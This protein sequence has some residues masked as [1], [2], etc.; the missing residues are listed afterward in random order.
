MKIITLALLLFTAS[1]EAIE[2]WADTHLPVTNG[3]ALWLDAASEGKAPTPGLWHDG[4]GHQRHAHQAAAGA[5]PVWRLVSPVAAFAFDGQSQHFVIDTRDWSMREATVFVVARVLSNSGGYRGFLSA[6]RPGA[7]DYVTGVN[8]DLGGSSSESV[9]EMNIEGA[10]FAGEQNLL[11]DPIPFGKP[12]AADFRIGQDK[13]EA[14]LSSARPGARPRKPGGSMDAGHV[15]IGA[16]SFDNGGRSPVPHGFLHGDVFE[17]LVYDRALST[18]EIQSVRHYLSAKYAGVASLPVKHTEQSAGSVP[19]VAVKNPPLIQPLVPGFTARQLP[20]RLSNINFLRYRPDGRLFAGAYDGTIY[21]LRDTDGDGLPDKATIYYQ[22]A[23]LKAVM[24]MALTPP[25]YARGE[26]VFV[27][28]Q[29]RVILILDTDGDGVGDEVVTV[30]SGWEHA[31]VVTQGVSDALGVAVGPDGKIYFNLGTSDFTNGYL[32]DRATGKAGYRLGSERGTIQ[33]VSAD[34]QHRATVS[35]GLRYNVGL[36][37][38]RDGDL[39]AT[40][41]EGATW[42]ANGNPLDELLHIQ[43]GRHYG[44]P[45]HHPRHLPEVVDEP[46]TFDYAPQHQSTVGLCFNEPLR[47]GAPIFGPGWWRGDALIAAMSRGKIYRTTLVKT[48]AGYVARN[49][50]FAQLQRIIIDQAVS[51]AGALTVTLHSGAPDWGSGPKGLGELWQIEPMKM[52][53][54]QPAAAWSA[55]PTELRV[56]FDAPLSSQALAAMQ[57][58]VRV[59]QGRYVQA[60]DR[61]ETMRPGYQVVKNQLA[62]PRFPIQVRKV[63]LAE[64]GRTLVITTPARTAAVNYGIT[65]EADV[66]QVGSNQPFAGQIDLMADLTGLAAV[67]KA[68]DG[69]DAVEAWL[70]HLDF[71]VARSLTATG[72]ASDSFF[73]VLS[74]PG[75]ITLAGQLDLGLMLFPAVQPGSKLDWEY[76]A[77]KVTVQLSAAR[78]FRFTLGSNITRSQARDGRHEASCTVEASEGSWFGLTVAFAP[79]S[80]NPELTG[81]WFTDRS[82]IPRP[83]PLRRILLPYARPQELAPAVQ[84]EELPQL[85]GAN[86]LRGQA[87]FQT[88]CVVCH[89]M[90]GAGGRVGPD[91]S[92]L[93]YRDYDSVLRDIREPSAAINPEHV[94][95]T[96]TKKNGEELT[97]VLLSD[98]PD[99]VTLALASG[100]SV[101]IPRGDIASMKQL[102]Q[103]LMPEG[104]DK[105]FTPTQL[106]DLMSYLLIPPM[107]PAPLVGEEAPAPRKSMEVEKILGG[108][109]TVGPDPKAKPLRIVLCAS[110]KDKGHN[111]PGLHDYP[112]WRQ[113]WSRLLAMAEGMSV[114]TSNNWPSAEQWSTADVIAINSYNPA[115]ADEK[116]PAAIDRR[117]RDI[118][119]FLARG[120]GLVV[121]HY[122]LNSGGH[123]AEFASRVGLAW[124]AGSRFR[125]GAS[126]WV[127]DHAHPLA[128]GFD[129]FQIPD[130]SY[131][132]LT[133]N[134]AAAG[135]RVLATSL[136]DNAPRPQMWTREVGPGRVFVSIPGHFTWTYD[137]PLYR[138]LIFR[139]LM[140][141]AH[142]PLD[143]L[144]PL[145]TI[146]ARIEP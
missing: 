10:G 143:R 74:R 119:A 130:E 46:S 7:N 66:F 68:T 123:A 53:P 60:G 81:S 70:P 32:V 82:S 16:R 54:P 72:A 109:L 139:G 59:T 120:G 27:A 43:R 52:L 108:A 49:Q 90:R 3:L 126:D 93:I 86:W 34:F 47:E 136:E 48:A 58:R 8:I 79:G 9:S 37:F 22:S 112:I 2:P 64:A 67:W 127:L 135:A 101:E 29:G 106:R 15:L 39:F 140:W 102:A 71:A 141:S 99:S 128:A 92:N 133:G 18:A 145:V 144:A 83:F 107:E 41:Q 21:L 63:A 142:Q 104:M 11:P 131:W 44:F 96:M 134:L 89:P 24:G 65:I 76:P 19:L 115:W 35:T 51:P 12:F 69:P 117:G 122:A 6:S 14:L 105:I 28:S 121:L 55:S 31:V 129:G 33:E 88:A 25:G 30:A 80:G 23:D 103:S 1:V 132:N 111:V 98:T 95:Y 84:Q 114:E 113:R 118:D 4:S 5:Q 20:V 137:D 62:T 100:Q 57:G 50:I 125:H 138:I 42:L 75:T 87:H 13:V 78:P 124:G 110:D 91:L 77:E 38:N 97:A 40:E 85:T 45:P 116:D 26:G 146:G 56:S 17:V 94:A 73:Q 61:F 36:A